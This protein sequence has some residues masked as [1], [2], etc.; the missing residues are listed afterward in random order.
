MIPGY[1]RRAHREIADISSNASSNKDSKGL[2]HLLHVLVVPDVE[3]EDLAAQVAQVLPNVPNLV[4]RPQL[5][6]GN[7]N[8]QVT[9]VP[10]IQA[11]LFTVK[12]RRGGTCFDFAGS[13]EFGARAKADVEE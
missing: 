8:E 9:S 2:H 5:S 13:E 3:C 10:D 4:L 1:R 7:V 11:V 6:S 12:A